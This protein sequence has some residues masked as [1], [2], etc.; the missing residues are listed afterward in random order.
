M[1]PSDNKAP[2]IAPTDMLASNQKIQAS[3]LTSRTSGGLRLHCCHV[4]EA[5]RWWH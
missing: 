2:I 3:I 1:R 5:N 4:L